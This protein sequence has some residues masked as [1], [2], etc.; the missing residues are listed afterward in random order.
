M[1]TLDETLARLA[2]TFTVRDIMIPSADLVCAASDLQAPDVSQRN[3]DFNVIPI[4]E[5]QKLIKY[6]LRDSR[7]VQRIELTDVIADGTSLLD[8]VEVFEQHEFAFVL[9]HRQIAGY[10]HFS[11]LNHPLIKLMYYVI[12]EAVERCVLSLIPSEDPAF[13]QRHLPRGRFEQIRAQYRRSGN[14]GRNLASYLN[15]AD[16]LLL[17]VEAQEIEIGPASIKALKEAQRRTSWPGE[18]M[19]AS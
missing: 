9:T 17:A 19:S 2:G 11:D 18:K 7:A 10:V 13:L 6:F 12:L 3:S 1:A 16:S 4:R 14:A 15:I 8:L 5:G